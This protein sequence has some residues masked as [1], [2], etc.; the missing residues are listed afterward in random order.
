MAPY[1][2]SRRSLSGSAIVLFELTYR[3]SARFLPFCRIPPIAPY[4]NPAAAYSLSV[5]G[6]EYGLLAFGDFKYGPAPTRDTR[7]HEDDQD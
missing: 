2:P 3:C 4:F 7:E 5:R 6:A 1:L